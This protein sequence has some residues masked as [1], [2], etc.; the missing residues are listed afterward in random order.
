[1]D[2]EL[3]N[4][5]NVKPIGISSAFSYKG[6]RVEDTKSYKRLKSVKVNELDIME[7]MQYD[8]LIKQNSHEHALQVI[9]NTVEGDYSQ[10]STKL[11]KIAQAEDKELGIIR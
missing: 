8:M 3:P 7:Q 6:K 10:L 2:K 11:A 5:Y 9:I 1:M 4:I